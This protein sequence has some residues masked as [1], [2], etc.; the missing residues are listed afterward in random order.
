[1]LFKAPAK[2]LFIAIAMGAAL[3]G[4]AFARDQVISASLAQPAAQT[5]FVANSAVWSC[6]GQ[7]CVA[8]TSQ[9]ATVRTCRQFVREAGV[10]VTAFGPENAP[11]TT[12]AL[13][14]C[15]EGIAPEVQQAQN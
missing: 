6:E 2:A 7:S 15:N 3:S 12:E 9:S 10:A 8:R 5:Q 14:Q 11:L 1:M 13:A 4:T